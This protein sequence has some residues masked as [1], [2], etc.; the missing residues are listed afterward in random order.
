MK[1]GL[2]ASALDAFPWTPLGWHVTIAGEVQAQGRFS[3]IRNS[4]Y[5]FCKSGNLAVCVQKAM[6]AIRKAMSKPCGV[7]LHIDKPGTPS[8][9]SVSKIVPTPA[10]T[11]TGQ[12][13][14][15]CMQFRKTLFAHPVVFFIHVLCTFLEDVEKNGV[16]GNPSSP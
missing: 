4:W 2:L 11:L 7:S 9:H 3:I 1:Y 5:H 13:R 14:K 16:A 10:R 8:T 15:E 6:E 12:I